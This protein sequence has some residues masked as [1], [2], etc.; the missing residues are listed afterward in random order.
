MRVSSAGPGINLH[1]TSSG[2]SSPDFKQKEA[3]VCQTSARRADRWAY[4]LRSRSQPTGCHPHP[5]CCRRRRQ[6]QLVRVHRQ[7]RHRQRRAQ[8]FRRSG[9]A[10]VVSHGDQLLRRQSRSRRQDRRWCAQVEDHGH[11]RPPRPRPGDRQRGGGGETR[12]ARGPRPGTGQACQASQR[13]R[14]RRH[15]H[16]QAHGG[17]GTAGYRLRTH[18]GR[19]GPRPPAQRHLHHRFIERHLAEPGRQVSRRGDLQGRHRGP[20]LP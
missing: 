19:V 11:H 13:N 15:H 1:C 17:R 6:G 3:H 10:A 7:A 18:Q 16:Q 8:L 4:R 20:G 9:R 12:P 2:A 5:C 14:P